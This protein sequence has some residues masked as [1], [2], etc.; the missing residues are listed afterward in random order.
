[1][2]GAEE[3]KFINSPSLCQDLI[4][5]ARRFRRRPKTPDPPAGRPGLQDRGTLLDCPGGVNRF[6]VLP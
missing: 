5:L 3:R 1:M 4:G 2:S 6:L